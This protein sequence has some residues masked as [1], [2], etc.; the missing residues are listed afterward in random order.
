MQLQKLL[1]R[2]TDTPI[3]DQGNETTERIQELQGEIRNIQA[4]VALWKSS[5]RFKNAFSAR[6]DAEAFK[7]HQTALQKMQEEMQLFPGDIQFLVSLDIRDMI[8]EL[9]S[10]EIQKE[11]RRL[12]DRLGDGKHGAQGNMLQDV[13]CFP[14]TRVAILNDVDSWIAD[15]SDGNHVLWFRGMAGRGKSTI[16]STILH[17]WKGR[18]SCAIFHFRRGQTA[19]NAR[20]ICALARQLGESLDPEIKRAVLDSVRQN[21]DI[22]DKRLEEQFETLLVTPFAKTGTHTHPTVFILDALDESNNPQDAVDILSLIHR[23]SSSF[24]TNVKFVLTSR[25]ELPLVHA[26]ERHACKVVDLESAS[27]VSNDLK[28]FLREKFMD[29]RIARSIRADWPSP[30]EIDRVVTISQGLFQW[31]RTVITYLGEG[32]P[33][34]RLQML[35]KDPGK[36]GGLDEL[37]RQILQKAFHNVRLEPTR[38]ELLCSVLGWLVV[39]PV[40]VS[41]EI[42]AALYGEQEPLAGV[43]LLDAVDF[44]RNDLLVDVV[45]LLF[46]PKAPGDPMQLM[47]TSVR[48]LLVNKTRCEGQMYY[49]NAIQHHQHLAKLCMAHM[50]KTLKYN[51]CDLVQHWLLSSEI[52]DIGEQKVAN[53]V[54]Y[55]CM[56]WSTHLTE[57]D[58]AL[59]I[60]QLSNFESFSRKKLMFW[61]EVISLIGATAETIRMAKA[62]CHWLVR[63]AIS[64]KCN[65]LK[66]LWTDLDRFLSVFAVPIA[67]GPLH[68]Y[69][70]ALSYCPTETELWRCY[71]QYAP[72]RILKGGSTTWDS[73]VWTRYVDSGIETVRWSSDGKRIAVGTESGTV[74]LYDAQSGNL[75]GQP[76]EGHDGW[77]NSVCFSLDGKL[78]A[79]GSRDQT[80]RLWNPPTGEAIGQPLEGH[81]GGV[82]SV[83]FSPDGKLL[84]SG[85]SDKTIRLWNP[86]TAEAI[87]Q[88]LEGHDS[89]VNLV[90]FSPDG[91]LLASGSSDR[92]IRLWNPQTGEAIGQPLEGHDN[93]VNSVCFSPDRKLLAS[94]SFDK[95]IRLWKPQTGEA[96]GQPLEG[97]DSSVNSVCFSPD[98]KLLASGSSDET[99]RL[100]NPQT[101]EA[102]CRP[103]EGHDWGVSSVCFSPDGK[104]LASGSFDKTIRLW[105][106]QTGEAIGQPY[107]SPH[108]FVDFVAVSREERHFIGLN[109]NGN[110]IAWQTL[111]EPPCLCE[112]NS[113][114]TLKRLPTT[115]L[116]P[117]SVPTPRHSHYLVWHPFLYQTSYLC[118]QE[119]AIH[120]SSALM[121]VFQGKKIA[122]LDISR[123]VPHK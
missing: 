9:K 50:L 75:I 46:I 79:S 7:G 118:S 110:L 8:S 65:S 92:T 42:V 70:S 112:I 48:D 117:T 24:P 69:T 122:I 40:P 2:L 85:S 63:T 113:A 11:K 114:N 98:G 101:G 56:S 19:L 88:P 100:W 49:V 73:T 21:E 61:L 105:N 10:A 13:V 34:A 121:S 64:L 90:C 18:A 5:G 119:C 25:P 77:V 16:A 83:C 109:S 28:I 27:D 74:Q 57:G 20:V 36:W 62:L 108:G 93:W 30:E 51:M 29:L 12:L 37:Y 67:T 31:A 91:K 47:H 87:G 115:D 72:V 14:G 44:L 4:T 39:A 80:I 53:V 106:P 41:L 32:S 94:G 17:N 116:A 99:I 3:A 89:S 68:I 43:D 15:S 22:A 33:T 103:L 97:H 120:E 96:I 107:K 45:S 76:L 54:R 86:Q 23:L 82:N 26:L 58:T 60:D 102:I 81:D 38:K 71:S 84:A 66:T 104:L 1:K 35:L 95:T 6:D 52:Q 78:L 123:I 59:G 111:P 55:C